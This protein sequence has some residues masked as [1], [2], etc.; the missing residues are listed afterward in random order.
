[1]SLHEAPTTRAEPGGR[2]A[3]ELA[4]QG[5][6]LSVLALVTAVLVVRHSEARAKTARRLEMSRHRGV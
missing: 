3:T 1:M 2:E 6:G 4:L 5:A